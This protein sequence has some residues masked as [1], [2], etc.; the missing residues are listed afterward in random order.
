MSS[1]CCS[2]FVAGSMFLYIKFCPAGQKDDGLECPKMRNVFGVFK[3]VFC[4][5]YNIGAL[6]Q[7][8]VGGWFTKFGHIPFRDNPFLSSVFFSPMSWD[9]YQSE[10]GP[11]VVYQQ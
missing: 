3:I 5:I 10:V 9:V 8:M 4:C 7:S 2:L 11:H 1:F 6:V